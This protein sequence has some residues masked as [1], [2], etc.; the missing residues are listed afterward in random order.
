MGDVSC[1]HGFVAGLMES[2]V[3][4]LR[5]LHTKLCME[6]LDGGKKKVV[7]HAARSA[8]INHVCAIYT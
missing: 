3:E 6:S 7:I 5:N 4:V 1:H 8:K 2:S